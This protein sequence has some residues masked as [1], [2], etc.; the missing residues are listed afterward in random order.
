[1]TEQLHQF[2]RRLAEDGIILA[3][4][5][6]ISQEI[7]VGYRQL[8]RD[9]HHSENT[10]FKLTSVFIELTENIF[11]YS[12]DRTEHKGRNLGVGIVVVSETAEH[13]LITS[14]NRTSR[15]ES[16]ILRE[17]C[18][19]LARLDASGLREEYKRVRRERREA[20]QVGARLGLIEVARRSA[21]PIRCDIVEIDD[22]SSFVTLEIVVQKDN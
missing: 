14:G 16:A 15:S 3:F 17:H 5:G 10:T 7:M 11:R 8:L 21:Q 9:S 20:G 2:Y 18:G 12:A 1:M 19:R 13:F 4:L 6:V 22:E